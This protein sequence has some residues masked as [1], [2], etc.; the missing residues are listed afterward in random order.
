MQLT[1][2]LV[3]KVDRVVIDSGP[4]AGFMPMTEGDYD[5]LADNHPSALLRGLRS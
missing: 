1:P 2:E 5:I 4:P 3:A